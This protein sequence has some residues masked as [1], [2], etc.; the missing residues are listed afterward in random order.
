MGYVI[1]SYCGYV[2]L[3]GYLVVR[4]VGFC[5]VGI[6]LNLIFLCEVIFLSWF[7]INIGNGL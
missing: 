4:L 2:Y 3:L 6:Y 5:E 1:V 7:W